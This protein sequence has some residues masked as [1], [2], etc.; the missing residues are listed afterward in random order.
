MYYRRR[1]LEMQ[2]T[3]DSS[4]SNSNPNRTDDNNARHF[5]PLPVNPEDAY[6]HRYS[7]TLNAPHYKNKKREVHESRRMQSVNTVDY[8]PKKSN[9]DEIVGLGKFVFI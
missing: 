5:H 4:G 6:A 3:N 9:L 7:Q 1:L 8:H 2:H